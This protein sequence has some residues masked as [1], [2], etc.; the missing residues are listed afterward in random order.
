MCGHLLQQRLQT[1]FEE[2]L[3]AEV[4]LDDQGALQAAIYDL[5]PG[6]VSDSWSS[7]TEQRA[8]GGHSTTLAPGLTSFQML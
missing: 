8:A 4:I 5:Q 7:Q 3:K 1:A 2:H 6:Q